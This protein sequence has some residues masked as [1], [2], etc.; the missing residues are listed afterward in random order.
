M[1]KCVLFDLD[2]VLVD[3]C[4]WH[5]MAL[6]TALEKISNTS[7]TREEHESTFNGLPTKT[8]LNMLLQ[9]NR[10]RQE[11][12]SK[13]WQLKQELTVGIISENAEISDVKVDLHA[14]LKNK[15]LLVGCVTNSIRKT[16]EMMLDKTGQLQSMDLVITN[17]DVNLPKP[18]PEGYSKAMI[19]CD[20]NPDE[21]VIFEDSEKGMSAALD[22]G[23][24]TVQVE[25]V[26]Q[27]NSQ[28]VIEIIRQLEKR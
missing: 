19:A 20:V 24:Y 7:I 2:G 28:F 21:T 10:I 13:I 11:D 8:K 15:G 18:N 1:I 3:A 23:A 5:Y 14:A 9:E 26:T 6:N 25:S 22:S 16:A 4:E 17:E 12:I 27:I